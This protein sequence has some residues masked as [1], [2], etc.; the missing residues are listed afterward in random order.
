MNLD[1]APG[2]YAV[3]SPVQFGNAAVMPTLFTM[4]VLRTVS[5]PPCQQGLPVRDR[6]PAMGATGTPT[7]WRNTQWWGLLIPMNLQMTKFPT[8]VFWCIQ[9]QLWRTTGEADVLKKTTAR[10]IATLSKG[11]SQKFYLP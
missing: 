1:T 3:S 8:A 10:P 2:A 6:R 11:F 5:L 7:Q 4:P 9:L